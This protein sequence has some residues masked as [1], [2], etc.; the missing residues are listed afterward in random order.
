LGEELG[1]YTEGKLKERKVEVIKRAR[2]A[3]FDLS[4]VVLDD[5]RTIPTKTLVWTAGVKPSCVIDQL[6]C[7]KQK[8]RILVNEFLAVPEE[9]GVWACGDSAAVPDPHTKD[10]YPP[11]AQHGL[12]E[13]LVAAKNIESAILGKPLRPFTYKTI[14]QLASIGHHTGV[15]MVFGF[16]FSG[17]FAWWMWR[18][19][20]LAKLPR[21]PKKLRVVVDWTLDLLFGR[22]I[23][24]M[25]TLRDVENLTARVA[26]F[27]AHLTAVKHDH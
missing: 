25:I 9:T 4:A 24:Q 19:V 11:T 17:F 13:G 2:V 23:E 16:K 5:G 14:G 12:R 6:A 22:E 8:H 1:N 18:T 27:R 26:K 15:A 21:W 3:S 20:Y 7:P 10:F